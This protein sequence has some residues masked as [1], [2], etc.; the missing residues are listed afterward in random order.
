L[1]LQH[2]CFEILEW[3]FSLGHINK[4]MFEEHLPP[5]SND[6]LIMVCGPKGM[7]WKCALP[8]LAT[9]GYEKESIFK[10]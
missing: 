4:Q 10:Y 9:M 1:I 3:T 7:V 5:P 8:L 6:T 2:I